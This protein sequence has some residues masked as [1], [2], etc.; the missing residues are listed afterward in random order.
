MFTRRTILQAAAL[1]PFA[2]K[3]IAQTTADFDVPFES[4]RAD[5]SGVWEL[6]SGT[7]STLVANAPD[8][9]KNSAPAGA[10]I[11]FASAKDIDDYFK[12]KK[13][14]SFIDWFNR[15]LAGKGNFQNKRIQGPNVASN[16]NNYWTSYLQSEPLT[17]MQFLCYMA[18]HINE[19]NGNL[20]SITESYGHK[21]HPGISYLFDKVILKTNNRSWSKASYNK[22]YSCLELFNSDVF[23][24]V[25]AKRTG[26]PEWPALRKTS[27]TIWSGFVYPQSKY[28]TSGDVKTTGMILHAD[29]FKFRGRGVIQ[30]TWRSNYRDIAKYVTEY[31]GDDQTIQ[32]YRDKW[33][34]HHVD[35]ICT[36]S[37]SLDWDE[38]FKSNDILTFAVRIHAKNGSNYHHLS[39]SDKELNGTGKGSIANMGDCIGG[40]G[41]GQRLKARIGDVMKSLQV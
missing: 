17:L 20:V 34:S 16:F 14:D 26:E 19:C 41:Y 1:I 9:P 23:L 10:K 2:T 6:N 5:F 13:G 30:T 18:V 40:A 27:D 25:H 38:I 32:K 35:E 28:P 22:N 36:I 39:G 29:F 3:A 12:S 11:V 7:I 37:T 15:D 33:R 24:D 4:G 31:V 21:D 8:L